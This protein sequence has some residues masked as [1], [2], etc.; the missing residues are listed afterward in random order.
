MSYSPAGDMDF[1]LLSPPRHS[2]TPQATGFRGDEASFETDRIVSSRNTPGREYPVLSLP[3][4]AMDFSGLPLEL[5]LEIFKHLSL[6]DHV[7][8]LQAFRRYEK[9]L[10]EALYIRLPP[11]QASVAADGQQ[12]QRKRNHHASE[13]TR[14]E[15]FGSKDVL[16]WAI[17]HGS[18]ATLLK[19]DS[20]EELKPLIN[21]LSFTAKNPALLACVYGQFEIVQLLVER[22]ADVNL[23]LDRDL[24]LL[25]IHFATTGQ[26]VAELMSHGGHCDTKDGISPL[27]TCLCC[28]A[29]VSAVRAFLK[30]GCSPHGATPNGTTTAVLAI[31]NADF[32]TLQ[33]L[34]DAVVDIKESLPGGAHALHYAICLAEHIP[35]HDIPLRMVRTLLHHGADAKSSY[36]SITDTGGRREPEPRSTP[37]LYLATMLPETEDIVELLLDRGADA[38]CYFTLKRG[39]LNPRMCSESDTRPSHSTHMSKTL[40]GE[41]IRTTITRPPDENAESYI[42]PDVIRK[43]NLLALHGADMKHFWAFNNYDGRIDGQPLVFIVMIPHLMRLGADPDYL[44]APP[45][46]GAG[47]HLLHFLIESLYP[48]VQDTWTEA[49]VYCD[50]RFKRPS[51][52]L[53]AMQAILDRGAD[54]NATGQDE[55]T[56]LMLVCD[57]NPSMTATLLMKALLE[58]GKVDI[59]A[60]ASNGQ[61]AL[62]IA[63][64][65]SLQSSVDYDDFCLR[66]QFLLRYPESLKDVNTRDDLGRTPI[67]GLLDEGCEWVSPGEV[68]QYS[69]LHTLRRALVMLIRS[70]ADTTA[71]VHPPGEICRHPMGWFIRGNVRTPFMTHYFGPEGDDFWE[72]EECEEE[73]GD[74]P[75]HMACQ[76]S[77]DPTIFIEV[78][79]RGCARK[80]VNAVS[81]RLR[82]T[83]LMM[84]VGLAA[85]G[86][87]LREALM[88]A[89]NLLVDAG[90]GLL[91][92][93]RWR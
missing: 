16:R 77:H 41:L 69:K 19:I 42:K 17:E 40:V 21:A 31:K 22:G 74:T 1:G 35:G 51:F 88:R 56:P 45:G 32:D 80:D 25:P 83:P 4:N 28:K 8:C 89:I 27:V 37:Y 57:Q 53:E 30:L 75:L 43:L 18:I 81:R 64:R 29:D 49:Q 2:R 44:G 36:E 3:S 24:G 33:V 65:V 50:I 60:K 7:T 23:S 93:S 39:V 71:R 59:R 73:I 47:N 62:H 76:T 58:S 9:A 10:G 67:H 86:L 12:D 52:L 72:D 26:L 48:K 55:A 68:D 63:S 70:G 13:N 84:L 5:N 54:P 14:T 20:V 85:K 11:I 38:N 82:L 15:S 78:L 91:G 90:V 34:L 92:W 46:S 66:L 61:T 6:H 87:V 79:L